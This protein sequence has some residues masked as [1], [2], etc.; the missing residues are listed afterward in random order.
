M[1]DLASGFWP[2][3]D[4]LGAHGGPREPR[5]RPRLESQCWL[6]Q[7]SAPETI[8]KSHSWTLWVFGTDRKKI[9]IQKDK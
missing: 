6:H 1:I 5:E 2:M 3:F 4:P 9:K 7:E 8:S